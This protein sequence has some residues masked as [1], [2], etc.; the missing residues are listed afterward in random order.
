MAMKKILL[1]SFILCSSAL[2]LF[3]QLTVH[4]STVPIPS[5]TGIHDGNATAAVCRGSEPYEVIWDDDSSSH[6][7]HGYRPCRR[8]VLQGNRYRCHHGYGKRQ[9]DAIPSLKSVASSLTPFKPIPAWVCIKQPSTSVPAE[10]P[11]PT[12]MI[13]RGPVHTLQNR[14]HREPGRRN[15]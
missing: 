8:Q 12:C 6:R 14:D 3:P 4:I 10:E 9:C 5:C 15:V 1:I 11:C 2:Y 13:G 7:T